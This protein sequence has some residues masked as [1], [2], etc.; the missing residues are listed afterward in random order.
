MERFER[1]KGMKVADCIMRGFARSVYDVV[2]SN[3]NLYLSDTDLECFIAKS[4]TFKKLPKREEKV[5]REYYT[6]MYDSLKEVIAQRKNNATRSEMYA[7]LG[8][9]THMDYNNVNVYNT[10]NGVIHGM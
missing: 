2:M 1:L 6:D 5:R 9:Y 8:Q 7:E 3:R 10:L 4:N